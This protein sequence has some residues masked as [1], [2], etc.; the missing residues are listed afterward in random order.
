MVVATESLA[1]CCP[2]HGASACWRVLSNVHLAN[3]VA[4][5]WHCIAITCQMLGNCTATPQPYNL[6]HTH[7]NQPHIPSVHP[8][9]PGPHPTPSA[10][11]PC[12]ERDTQMLTQC[13]TTSNSH[14]HQL[15][16]H[17][18]SKTH[19]HHIS[20][21]PPSPPLSKCSTL[22]TPTPLQVLHPKHSHADVGCDSGSFTM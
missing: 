20:C 15:Q 11:H 4:R 18:T 21:R 17:I 7:N 13:H 5:E 22:S 6:T 8:Q 19:K 16:C 12:N 3:Q 1:T 9:V 14:K 10:P 2:Q